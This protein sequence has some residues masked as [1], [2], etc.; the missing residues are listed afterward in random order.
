MSGPNRCYGSATEVSRRAYFD[1]PSGWRQ[2]RA[3]IH[4]GIGTDL[5]FYL[6]DAVQPPG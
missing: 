6:Q 4:L 1:G 3:M 5:S 2:T